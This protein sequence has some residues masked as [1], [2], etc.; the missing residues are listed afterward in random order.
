MDI[1]EKVDVGFIPKRVSKDFSRLRDICTV[2]VEKLGKVSMKER[3]E[4]Q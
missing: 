4:M 1:E 2:Y 3:K